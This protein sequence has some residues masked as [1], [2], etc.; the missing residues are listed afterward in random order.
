MLDP[1]RVPLDSLRRRFPLKRN[2]DFAEWSQ[3][4]NSDSSARRKLLIG[5]TLALATVALFL[6]AVSHQFLGY[7][8][9]D[10]VTD[11]PHVRAGLT[12]SG[13]VWAFKSF[14]A[15][16]WHPLTW[17]SHMLDCQIYGLGPAGHHLTNVLLH[18]ANVVLL[19]VALTRLTG[20]LWRSAAVAAL[21]AWHPLHVESVAWVAER[22]DLLCA[23]FW[24]LTLWSYARY[25][26]ESRAQSSVTKVFGSRRFFYC[27]ALLFFALALMSK[28][29]AVTLPFVLL[30]LDYW[31][32]Q[33]STESSAQSPH[34][35]GQRRPWNARLCRGLLLEKGPFIALSAVGCILTIEAQGREHAI[36]STGGLPV[37]ERV[38]HALVSYGHYLWATVAPYALAVHYPHPRTT[39]TL[40]LVAALLVLVGISLLA[41]RLAANRPYLLVGWLWFMGTLVPVIGLVQ[42]GEQAW[43]DRYTY[44]PLIG[45]FMA[46]VWCVGDWVAQPAAS[47]TTEDRRSSRRTRLVA[48]VSALVGLAM[49]VQTV[50]QLGY[51]KDT[52]TLFAHAA[53]VTGKN[54]RALTMLGRAFAADGKLDEAKRL[55]AEALSHTADDPETHFCLGKVL[56][57][58]GNLDSAIAE[59][60]QA[61]R[62]PQ[63]REPAHVCIGI[64]LAKEKKYNEAV[65]HYQEALRLN[66]ES[67][68]AEHNLAHLLRSEGRF[69]EAVAH[70]TAALKDDPARAETHNNLGVLFLEKGRLAEGMT[71]LQE[72]L[73]LNPDYTE[74]QCNLAIAL[75]LQEK[76]QQAAELLSTLCPKRPQDPNLRYQFALALYH[77]NRV[78]EARSLLAEALVIQRDFPPALDRLAW[79]LATDP[80]DDLRNGTQA[81]SMAE[82]AC[83]LTQHKRPQFMA[84][85]AAAYA[86]VGRFGEAETTAQKA[87]SL[88]RDSGQS[89]L[90]VLSQGI[91]TAAK[92]GR[93]WREKLDNQTSP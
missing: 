17:L 87:E 12:S 88:A 38:S 25:V 55:Y 2:F 86:E 93:P 89:A 90:V 14:Y 15:S 46:F 73:R 67:A 41:I 75:N 47:N 16:N 84:T 21:F 33:T 53:A 68:A 57:Q 70:Y 56:D 34:P 35:G 78:R 20:S 24:L 79:L 92:S 48:V 64:A 61:L 19:F 77:L 82:R 18:A 74:A 62:S 42:V 52:R 36:A 71:Q 60:N 83:E 9:Q 39:P 27:L 65:A 37:S 81:V 80:H 23:F 22:K 6:P 63:F 10:Y 11:N 50:R 49:A 5:L 32:L 26:E 3:V 28:P 43:A 51:W 72:A 4:T 44:L 85:L 7:D 69:D 1:K 59:F 13:I 40:E 76:W 58:Q 8:D 31:P 45:I 66:P 91:A 30:L 54:T 29:M